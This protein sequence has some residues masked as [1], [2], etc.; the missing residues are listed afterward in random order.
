MAEYKAGFIGCGSM[1]GALV[2]ALVKAIPAERIA[3]SGKSTV[4]ADRLAAELG[5]V[6]TSMEDIVKN[7]EWLFLATKPQTFPKVLTEISGM[8][9]KRTDRFVLVSVAAGLEMKTVLSYLENDCPLIRIMPN[10][11]VGVGAGMTMYCCSAL[12]TDRDREEFADLMAFSGIMDE[13]DEKLMDAGCAVAG[14][15]PAFA[16][17]FIEALADGGVKCG[18]PRQKALQ[19]A[20]Q[21]VLGSAELLLQ[22]GKHPGVLKDEVCSPGGSTIEGVMSLE[23]KGF[24]GAAAG[25]VAAAFEKNRKLGKA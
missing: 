5:V 22:S 20:A 8:L 3:V 13:V 19:Y 16:F 1:G 4:R 15:G 25:A 21:T 14:C 12:I 17:L 23:E 11:P 18:L 9:K 6:S 2:R 10:T 24:R 7:S